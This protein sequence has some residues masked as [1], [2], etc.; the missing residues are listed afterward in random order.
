[1]NGSLPSSPLE[2][3]QPIEEV[4]RPGSVVAGSPSVLREW[5]V[6]GGLFVATLFSTTFAGLFYAGSDVNPLRAIL[7]AA[8]HPSILLL[9][10]PFSLTLIG[11]LLAHEMGHFLACRFYGIRCTPPFFIPF[12]VTFAGTLGAFIRIKSPFLDRKALF[13]VGAAGPIAGFIFVL[14]AL[15]VGIYHSRLIPK[16]SFGGYSFGEPLLFRWLGKIILGYSPASQDMIA[17]PIAMAAWFGL[18][19]TCL[20]LF[21]IWQLDGGHI[22]YALLGRERHRRLSI[23]ATAALILVSFLGWPLPSYLLFGV[24]LL[25][26]EYRTRFYHPPTLCDECS[27]G[28]ARIAVGVLALVILLVCFTPV[29]ISLT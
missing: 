24:L 22:A 15:A 17:H 9:G 19:V 11:I 18:L 6:P 26:V 16:G 28:P 12:P 20:N 29:P 5:L 14:P 7:I 23:L 2:P 10:L 8:S 1:V 3:P 27:P 25:I 21:P 4:I 13:D